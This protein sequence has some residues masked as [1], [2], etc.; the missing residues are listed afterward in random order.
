M[1]ILCITGLPGSGKSTVSSILAEMGFRVI[2]M[3]DYVRREAEKMGVS[4]NEAATRLRVMYGSRIIARLVLEDLRR[5]NDGKVVIEGLRS[6]EEY[7]AFREGLGEVKLI[8]TVASL[9]VRF[10][11]LAS[12]GRLDDPKSLG[13]LMARDYRE[14]AFGLG[15]LIGLADYV[16]VNEGLSIEDLRSRVALIVREVYGEPNAG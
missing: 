14:L 16:I 1:P 9:G 7:E 11:R 15:D 4:S 12:R 3:G 6:R 13:D 5:L 2:V 10:R 8:F